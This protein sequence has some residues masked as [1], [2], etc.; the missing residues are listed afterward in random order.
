MVV[1][2]FAV[3][4]RGLVTV[5]LWPLKLSVELPLFIL[6]LGSAF[7]GFL[8]G[9]MVMWWS[10]GKQ[11]QKI[12]TMRSD[13]DRLERRN[14]SLEQANQPAAAQESSGLPAVTGGS[15]PPQSGPGPNRPAA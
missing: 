6:V 11:R 14:R 7:T 5:D 8:L 13:T 15:T 12:R 1:V 2:T 3:V 9:A 4:N 10:G